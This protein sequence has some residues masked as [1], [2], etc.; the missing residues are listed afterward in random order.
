MLDEVIP[1]ESVYHSAARERHVL[2]K[3]KRAAAATCRAVAEQ[4]RIGQLL[5][6][7]TEH[8]ISLKLPT[9]QLHGR[10][11]RIDTHEHF[12]AVIDYK[13][14]NAKFSHAEVGQGVQLQ[15]MLYLQALAKAGKTPIGAFYFPVNEPLIDANET[16]P[17]AL[18]DEK[19]LREFRPAGPAVAE[20]TAMLGATPKRTELY[21]QEAF[22]ALTHLAASTAENLTARMQT[23][24]IAPRP[25][26]KQQQK[27]PCRYCEFKAVCR[28]V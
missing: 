19:L 14:G 8:E 5:P 11:D 23:G 9:T 10:V 2:A 28:F 3:A 7:A 20:H 13:S 6:T 12:A 27:S 16:L 21:S 22:D 1:V 17:D 24:D 18:L 26:T 25:F 15:L 4:M